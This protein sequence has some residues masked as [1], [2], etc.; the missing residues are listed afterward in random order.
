MKISR[1]WL[2]DYVDLTGL[3]DEQISE[4]ITFLGFEVEGIE[5]TGA[6]QL[7]NVVVGEILSRDQHPNADRLSIC[8]VAVGEANGDTKRIVCGAQNYQAGDRVPVALIGAV[9]PGDFKIKPSKIRGEASE[10]M[11]CSGKEL[12][13]GEDHSGLMILTDRPEIGTP[14]NDALPDGDIVFDIEITPN[15]PDCQSH[16]GVARELAAWF[17]RELTYPNVNHAAAEDTRP[18]LLRD[19]RVDHAE[20]CLLY[21][22]SVIAGVKVGPSPSWMQERLSAVGVR[23]INNLV[24]VGNYVMLEYGQPMHAF[25]AKKLAGPSIIVRRANEGEKLTTLDEKERDLTTDMLVIADAEKSVVVAGIMGGENSGVDESTTDLVLE[26]AV[27]RRF[28]VRATSRALGL[29]SD[30][31]Y[32]FERGIDAHAVPEATSRAIALILETAGG[33]L[34]GPT[35]RVGSDVPWEREVTVNPS[36]V[37]SRLGFDVANEDQRSALEALD[38]LIVREKEGE[39]GV[40]WTVRIPSWRNDLDRPIDLVEEVLRVHGTAKIPETTVTGPGLLA[41]DDPVAEYNRRAGSYLIGQNFNECVTYSLRSGAEIATWSGE[42]AVAPLALDNPFVEDQSHLRSTMISGLLDT[43]KLNQSRGN[44]VSHLFETGRVFIPQKDV[45]VECAAVGFVIATDSTA[46]WKEREASD[47]YTTK[48]LIETLATQAG[49]DLS[50]QP[51]LPD[52]S[53]ASS[54]WQEGQHT[55][56]GDMRYGWKA[57]FGMLDLAGLKSRGIEGKVLAGVFAILPERLKSGGKRKRFQ[58]FSL[59]PAALRDVAL[60][61][62]QSATAGD[63]LKDLSKVARDVTPKSFALE[64]VNLFDVYEGKGLPAG[65]KSLAF[66]LKFRAADRTLKDEEVNKTFT[67]LLEKISAKDGYEIRQ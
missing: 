4:A 15:R 36:W 67:A 61:V 52:E 46:A 50:R 32:R 37:R 13:I 39:A 5:S 17:R 57:R 53:P 30:S 8:S 54:G 27:F 23:P 51:H 2:Q 31:S 62:P 58:P 11:M 40:E 25:D 1:N 10:G 20:D 7:E 33:T 41:N 34:C 26:V 22:G 18:D 3:S 44:A 29:S 9:L 49:V 35:L 45:V 21:T 38:L 64:D 60:I 48:R 12:Q 14:I 59:Q 56:Q 24:D 42:A 6:P 66:S 65:T 47:F 19:L 43:L 16:L 55:L 28:S 63:V